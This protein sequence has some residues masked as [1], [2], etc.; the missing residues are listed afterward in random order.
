MGKGNGIRNPKTLTYKRN[1]SAM[2]VSS[3]RAV[4][5]KNL[6]SHLRLMNL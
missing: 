2:E 1:K 3:I 4:T 5:A 6:P